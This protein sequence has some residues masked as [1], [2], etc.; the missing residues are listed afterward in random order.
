MIFHE[1]TI[2]IRDDMVVG[3]VTVRQFSNNYG[4]SVT[5]IYNW[6]G[7]GEIDAL[8]IGRTYYIPE[9]TKPPIFIS[10][11]RHGKKYYLCK[12]YE[13]KDKQLNDVERRIVCVLSKHNGLSVRA[14]CKKYQ[15]LCLSTVYSNLKSLIKKGLV[16]N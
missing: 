9:N 1:Q 3:Y 5:T 14:I 4:L 2:H 8:K 16:N 15:D 7:V 10:R 6:I 13:I 12:N 11:G